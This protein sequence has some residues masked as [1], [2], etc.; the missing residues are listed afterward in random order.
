MTGVYKKVSLPYK[1]FLRRENQLI[2]TI[3]KKENENKVCE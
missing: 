3:T 1:Q 2:M